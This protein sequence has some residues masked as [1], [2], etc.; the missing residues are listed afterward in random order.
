MKRTIISIIFT[1]FLLGLIT[2]TAQDTSS[3]E[4]RMAKLQ[5]KLNLT[6]EQSEAIEAI[7]I[8]SKEAGTKIREENEG[9]RRAMGKELLDLFKKTNSQIEAQL[10]DEQKK[11]YKEMIDDAKQNFKANRKNQN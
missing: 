3:V 8:D 10:T 5:E 1:F 6:E 9:N 11:I 2:I 7:L 4:E